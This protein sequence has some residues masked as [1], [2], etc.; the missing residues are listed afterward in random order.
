MTR[1]QEKTVYFSGEGRQFMQDCLQESFNYSI[2]HQVNKIII[3]TGSGEGP[4]YALQNLLPRPEFNHLKLVAVTPPF[5]RPYHSGPQGDMV[6]AGVGDPLKRVLSNSGIPVISAHLPFKGIQI[7]SERTSEWSR[8]GDA[9]G[10]L[11]GGFSLCVQSVLIACDAGYVDVGE[12]VVAVTAD[13]SV[14]VIATRTESFLSPVNGLIV[15]D[16]IARPAIYN[17][18][19]PQ[20]RRWFSPPAQIVA[21]SIPPQVSPAES[22]PVRVLPRLPAQSATRPTGKPP[23]PK[24]ST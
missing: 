7:G 6:R 16:I 5:G 21:N 15:E 3:F 17:I 4:L 9:F 20:H 11:G 10:I 18:S 19:K 12:T 23:K 24:K 13:T 2:L 14:S 8:V 22:H 1:R